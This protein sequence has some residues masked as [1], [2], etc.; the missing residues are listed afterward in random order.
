M[1]IWVAL[2]LTKSQPTARNSSRKWN[3]R[4]LMKWIMSTVHTKWVDVEWGSLVLSKVTRTSFDWQI[5][6]LFFGF[7]QSN[8]FRLMQETS[9]DS[10][11]PFVPCYRS[12]L[13]ISS[14][15]LALLAFDIQVIYQLAELSSLGIYSAVIRSAFIALYY[16]PECA[17]N[18]PRD[19]PW[20]HKDWIRFYGRQFQFRWKLFRKKFR[21]VDNKVLL[22]IV[23]P[24]CDF[25]Y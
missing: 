5:N 17:K 9:D 3:R 1:A 23:P 20:L 15:R 14:S 10:S 22:S 16:F 25:L 6:L 18:I 11:T 21:I 2:V 8:F 4:R 13:L 24:S 12:A 7:S 19:S